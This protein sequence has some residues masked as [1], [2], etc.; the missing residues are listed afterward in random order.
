MDNAWQVAIN[1]A[2]L[3]DTLYSPYQNIIFVR[4]RE[5]LYKEKAPLIAELRELEKNTSEYREYIYGRRGPTPQQ[6]KLLS[7]RNKI[8]DINDAIKMREDKLRDRGVKL[9]EYN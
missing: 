4:E 6:K 8:D 1:E 5:E 9:E 7:L 3:P 2:E